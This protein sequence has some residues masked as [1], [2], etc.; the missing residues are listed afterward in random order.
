[1]AHLDYLKDCGAKGSFWI[2]SFSSYQLFF[3]TSFVADLVWVS[4][5]GRPQYEFPNITVL[6]LLGGSWGLS[7]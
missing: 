4:S 7:K 5:R 2:F 6:P 3:C 1:M